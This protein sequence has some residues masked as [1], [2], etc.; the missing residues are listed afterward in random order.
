MAYFPNGCAGEVFDAQC[1][2]CRYG[3]RACPI[4]YV[5]IT[6]N[7]DACNNETARA[8]LDN[9][10]KDDGTCAMFAF[11]PDNFKDRRVSDQGFIGADWR[12]GHQ[13]CN[14]EAK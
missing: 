13:Q 2:R 12:E 4:A 14:S 6:Y 1:S 5:Q 8:I 9:L 10:V 7:Y 3:E 11:D